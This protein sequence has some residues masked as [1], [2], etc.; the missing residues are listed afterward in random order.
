M[1]KMNLNRDFALAEEIIHDHKF[2]FFAIFL[3]EHCAM[4]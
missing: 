2:S 4:I 3:L 1:T